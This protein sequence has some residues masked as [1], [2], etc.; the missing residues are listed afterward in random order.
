[1]NGWQR[2]WVVVSLILAILIGW[3]AYLLLPTEWGIT[4]NYDSRVEQL[5]RYLKESLEQEN[6]YP[7]RGEYIA[8]LR[9][10]IRKEKEN[11]PLELAKLPKERREHVTFAFGIWLALSVG[12]YIAGWL[13]GWI[14]RG[15]RPKKA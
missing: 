3:Y 4:N 13:V 5:T 8:S 9:E 14:Y 6:A 12:L 1:M 15:F 11:L 10:D 7:G 2:M